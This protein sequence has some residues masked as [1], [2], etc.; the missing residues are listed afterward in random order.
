[1]LT[2]GVSQRSAL[3]GGG[4]VRN[5]PSETC[6]R[7]FPL[8]YR[9]VS[10]NRNRDADGACLTARGSAP[11]TKE[12]RQRPT[13]GHNERSPRRARVVRNLMRCDPR[14]DES[15]ATSCVRRLRRPGT[16]L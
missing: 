7:E 8:L 10:D 3:G 2:A 13:P 14:C 5:L 6:S 16:R 12:G 15:P 4:E 11:E 1:V 9:G